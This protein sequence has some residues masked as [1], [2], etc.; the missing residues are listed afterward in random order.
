MF[1]NN[2]VHDGNRNAGQPVPAGFLDNGD[3]GPVFHVRKDQYN[4]LG[5]LMNIVGF[6][7]IVV[8]VPGGLFLGK[9]GVRQC[10]SIEGS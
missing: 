3:L 8:F 10:R 4:G 5:L 7:A 1:P 9:D 6:L 2:V